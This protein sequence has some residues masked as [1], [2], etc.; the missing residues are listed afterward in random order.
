M[1]TTSKVLPAAPNST[2][3]PGTAAEP[4]VRAFELCLEERNLINR[5]RSLSMNALVTLEI[6]P[7][8]KPVAIISIVYVKRERLGK[9]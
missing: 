7:Q 1:E 8:G 9:E 6:S 3:L 5:L 4:S 2:A